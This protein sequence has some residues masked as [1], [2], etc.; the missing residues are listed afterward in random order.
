MTVALL[1]AVPV[2][3]SLHRTQDLLSLDEDTPRLLGIQVPRARLILLAVA[4]LL[5]ASSVAGI[6][7]ISFV[8]LVAP[9]AARALVGPQHRLALPTAM[10]LGALLVCL[11]DLLGRTVIAPSQLPAG[12]LTAILGAPYFIYLLYR[13]RRHP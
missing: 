6:G 3:A 12:L 5:T 11:A 13:S 2:V 7:V 1:V 9:H 4:V 10:L 8:G